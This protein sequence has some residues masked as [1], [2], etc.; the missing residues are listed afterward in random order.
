VQW[1]E[2]DLGFIKKFKGSNVARFYNIF[3]YA[4]QLVVIKG[5]LGGF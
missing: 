1:I 3:K 5:T 2:F 4:L